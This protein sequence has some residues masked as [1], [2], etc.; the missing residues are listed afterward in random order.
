MRSRRSVLA[1]TV[2]YALATVGAAGVACGGQTTPDAPVAGSGTA[3]GVGVGLAD[4]DRPLVPASKV[5]V[6]F[7]VDNSAFMAA[8]SERLAKSVG[9]LL[10]DVARVGDV[11]VGVIASSLGTMGGDVCSPVNPESDGR[12]H[13]RERGPDGL[14]V[15]GL[16]SRVLEH[17]WGDVDA[18]VRSA[19]TLVRG[20]GAQGCGLEAQLEAAYRFL[21]QP[22][23]WTTVKLDAN[24]QADLGDAV[25]GELL[26]QR[27]AFLRPDSALVVVML[28]DEDDSSADPLSIGGQGWAFSARNFPGSQVTRGNPAQGTT[29]PRGTSICATSPGSPDCTSCAFQSLCDPAEA[30]CQK[31]RN[32]PACSTSSVPGL[33]G[34]GYRGYYGPREDALNVRYHRMKERFGIDPQFPLSR[35]VDGFSKSVVPNR[36]SEH[37]TRIGVNG[38]REIDPYAGVTSC[39]N[40]I[41]ASDLPSGPDEELC[42][43]ARGPRSR[44]LVL[45]AVVGGLPEELATASPDWI[46]ILGRDPDGYDLAGIDPH[47]IQSVEPRAGLGGAGAPLGNNGTDPAHGREWQTAGEDLEYA[48][49]F[50]LD[51]PRECPIDGVCDCG[52]N[53]ARNPPL[54]SKPGVQIRDKA[55]PTTRP[56][57]VARALGERALVGSVCAPSYDATMK[58][59]ST[60]LAPRLTR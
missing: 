39:Q 8:K 44:E 2:P 16:R 38:R 49:T 28:T 6:L 29:A 23:P 37:A 12:A 4:E 52:P 36:K 7:V 31:L 45:I 15:P 14:V 58:L 56:L 10:R 46:R 59:V 1:R 55:Y 47:M 3:T 54:C 22:D 24:N 57:R 53:E 21:V 19:E 9:T 41:F 43:R 18:F 50:A 25:D 60:R 17:S 20:V 5:D 11:H 32:D 40:P 51:A 48:C 34:D 27:K 13:L 42:A 30:S 26:A 35:Y 33:S